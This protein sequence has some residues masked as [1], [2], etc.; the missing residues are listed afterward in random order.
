MPQ[1]LQAVTDDHIRMHN[2][3]KESGLKYVAVMPPHI[4]EWG[5]EPSSGGATSLLLPP[6]GELPQA[7]PGQ[8]EVA[9]LCPALS[10]LLRA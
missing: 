3:L 6:S 8:S 9:D 2:V 10:I 7:F 4:G 1:R 5:W